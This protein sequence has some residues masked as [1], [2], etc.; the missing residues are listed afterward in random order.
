MFSSFSMPYNGSPQ[1][2]PNNTDDNFCSLGIWLRWCSP[3]M[4][5]NNSDSRIFYI[6]R[7]VQWCGTSFRGSLSNLTN[8]SSRC[9][10]HSAIPVGWFSPTIF[11]NRINNNV[12]GRWYFTPLGFPG[13]LCV[14]NMHICCLDRIRIPNLNNNLLPYCERIHLALRVFGFLAQLF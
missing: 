13:S 4:F 1:T 3:M 11:A 7:I 9:L 2:L 14:L 5:S 10:F 8:L 6:L 12:V